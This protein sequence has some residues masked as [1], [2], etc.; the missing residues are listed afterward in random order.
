[1]AL[2]RALLLLLLAAGCG[3]G[4]FD[5][6][7]GGRDNLPTRAAGPYSKLEIDF[8]TPADEP[9]VVVDRRAHVRDPAP[10][11]RDDGGVRLWFTHSPIASDGSSDTADIWVT[12]LPDL[13]ELPDLAPELAVAAD[14]DWE[15]GFI[16]EPSVVDLGDDHLVLYYRGGRAAPA[17][18]RADST[19]G[20]ATWDKHPDN[21]LL[22]D[23]LTPA[24]AALPDGRVIL[25]YTRPGATDAIL[26]ADSDDGVA[27]APRA[28]PVITPRPDLAEAFDADAVGD[29]FALVTVPLDASDTVHIGLFFTGTRPPRT[30]DEPVTSI[31]YA[32]SFDGRTFAR[33]LGPEPILAGGPPSE[34]GPAALLVPAGGV[35]FFQEA[36]QNRDRVAAAVH[37]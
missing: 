36:P 10:L 6:V 22:P 27:F 14:A 3:V 19:D 35:L 7:P 20:G 29:P 8:D 30:G 12:E 18:G 23:A 13:H 32:G 2:L 17:I 11:A 31:G 25:F 21:P 26:A 16:A 34:A 33:F 37:P 28:D 1:M 4:P 24:A 5:D 9:Y 15:E